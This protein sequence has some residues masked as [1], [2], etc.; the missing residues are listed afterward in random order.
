MRPR[1]RREDLLGI[2]AGWAHQLLQLASEHVQHH[3]GVAARVGV[4]HVL[5]R[6]LALEV[7]RVREVA[8]VHEHDAVRG[9]HVEGLSLELVLGFAAGGVAHVPEADAAHERAHVA[10]AEGLLDHALA[11]A[12]MDVRTVEGRDARRILAAVLQEPQRVVDLLVDARSRGDADDAAHGIVLHWL[13]SEVPAKPSRFCGLCFVVAGCG[14]V[15]FLGRSAV[16]RQIVTW[17]A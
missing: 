11:L 7:A 4:A 14:G 17:N 1:D 6:K 3:L 16:R 5:R 15:A 8:V 9:V 12:H 10:G 13:R 2:E